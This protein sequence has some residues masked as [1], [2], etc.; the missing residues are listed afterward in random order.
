M[1]HP[2]PIKGM[3]LAA[4]RGTRVR[5][6][7]ENIPKPMI[8]ILGHPVMEYLVAHLARHAVNQIM[9]NVAWHH[10]QIENYFGDGNRWGVQLGYSFEGMR[11]HGDIV[12]RPMG[13]AGAMRKIQ[14]F[15]GFF[16]CTT[17]VVCGD[18]LFDLNITA[19]V[20]EHR[21]RKAL[22]TVITTDVPREQVH[23]YGIVLTHDDDRVASFQEKPSMHEARS[24]RA[25]TGIYIFEPQVMELIPAGTPFDIGGDLFPLLVAQDMPFY[26]QNQKFSWIDIGRISDYWSVLQRVMRGEIADMRMP[27]EEIRPGIWVGL[28]T[29]IDW[30][31]VNIRGPVHIGSGARVEA[32]ASI[33]GPTWIGHGCHI[34][35]NASVTRSVLFEYTRIGAG[36]SVEDSILSP[37]YCVHRDGDAV[38]VGDDETALRWGDARL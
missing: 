9:V 17:L 27:G 21:K 6:L 16:D 24:T 22:A 23:N 5:P 18:A 36:M 14:D 26:A 13:S 31:K 33:V 38:F 20:A 30:P 35:P 19:A 28:N 12:P 32:G 4:G 8:P 2:A 34:R 11:D 10:A 7:T 37:Q 1:P 3:I 29:S 15:G 25:S